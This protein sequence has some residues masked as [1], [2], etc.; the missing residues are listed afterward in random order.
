MNVD[1]TTIAG[2]GGGRA[3]SEV[4]SSA[5]TLSP[6]LSAA[7]IRQWSSRLAEVEMQENMDDV[8]RAV[9]EVQQHMSSLIRY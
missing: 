9:R 5:D 7:L 6:R 4:P 3:A 1:D 2:G 8:R